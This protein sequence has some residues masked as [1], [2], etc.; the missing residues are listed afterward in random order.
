MLHTTSHCW[1]DCAA[2]VP[3]WIC[4]FYEVWGRSP[5]G[6]VLHLEPDSFGLVSDSRAS[7]K[8]EAKKQMHISETHFVSGDQIREFRVLA[9]L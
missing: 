7:R 9:L 5:S 4:I 1:Q 3:L 2:P 6:A 8:L